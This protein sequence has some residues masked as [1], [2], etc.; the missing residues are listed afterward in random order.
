MVRVSPDAVP[1]LPA[2]VASCCPSAVPK[3]VMRRLT[4]HGGFLLSVGRAEIGHARGKANAGD[5]RRAD[6][7]HCHHLQVAYAV[8]GK[9][10]EIVHDTSPPIAASRRK[11]HG[12]IV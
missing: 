1:D 12:P 6:E 4:G 5:Q 8:G 9:Q 11:V 3:S 7:R 2:M 10:R